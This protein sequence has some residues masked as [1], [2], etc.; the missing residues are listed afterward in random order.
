MT[1]E[2]SQ[3]KEALLDVRKSFRLLWGY[4]RRI[5]DIVELCSRMLP[6]TTP[7]QL[8][9]QDAVSEKTKPLAGDWFTWECTPTVDWTFLFLP[10]GRR[11]KGASDRTVFGINFTADTEFED[12]EIGDPDPHEFGPAE[13][14]ETVVYLS[15]YAARPRIQVDW[16][17]RWNDHYDHQM[18]ATAAAMEDEDEVASDR[19]FV[20]W[21]RYPL[22]EFNDKRSVEALINA[23]REEAARALAEVIQ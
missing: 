13:D 21:R 8:F 12:A 4:H 20:Y 11:S 22:D 5:R 9:G 10:T 19:Y 3:L 14:A 16:L 1:A 7:H 17:Q 2:S 23:F 6:G 18:E 15:M